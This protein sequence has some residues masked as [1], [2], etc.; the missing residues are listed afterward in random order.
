[1]HDSPSVVLL[2]SLVLSARPLAQ[3]ADSAVV[4]LERAD[5]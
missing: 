2:V 4:Y 3:G 1:M 5:N